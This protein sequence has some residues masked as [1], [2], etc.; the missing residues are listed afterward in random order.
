MNIMDL[1]PLEWS[2]QLVLTTAQLAEFY[3]CEP[4]NISDNFKRNEEH[5]I[6]GKHFYCVEGE[7]LKNLSGYFAK[8][9][10]QIS[11]KTRKIYLWT[12]RGAARHAK[13]LST[14]KAWDVYEELEDNYFNPSVV[15]TPA[16]AVTKP[17]RA[18]NPK[19]VAGQFTPARVYIFRLS[20]GQVMIVKIGQSNDVDARKKAVEKETKLSVDKCY[21]TPLLP[22]KVAR[23]IE[24]A[25]HDYFSPFKL[26][27][28]FFFCRLRDGVQV[29]GY[30]R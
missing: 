23:S 8:S 3:A 2:N 20:N 15:V 26:S 28:E 10:S 4:R 5:F 18:K 14:D 1:V 30:F 24:Q 9:E 13:M 12:E 25:C 11:S 6:E 22:R 19:R 7:A 21:Y 16:P 27:G 29:L 17:A